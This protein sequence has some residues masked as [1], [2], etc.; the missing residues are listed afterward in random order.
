MAASSVP[1]MLPDS[2]TLWRHAIE[3]L[4]ADRSPC[5]SL[6]PDRWATMRESALNFIDRF[7][8]EAHRLGWRAPELFGVHPEH[9]TLRLEMC[10][11]LM[12]SG[13]KADGV[14]ASCIRFGNQTGYRNKVGRVWGPPIWEFA[15]KR[16]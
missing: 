15:A 10:G 7:G 5:P 3:A 16:R 4:P 9:G 13:R 2:V 11:V 1:T 6:T 12:V 8:A 14:E